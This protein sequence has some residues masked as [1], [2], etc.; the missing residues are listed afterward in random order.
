MSITPGGNVLGL[1]AAEGVL[2]QPGRGLMRGVLCGL[3]RVWLSRWK[4]EVELPE[5]VCYLLHAVTEDTDGWVPTT[6]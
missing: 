2:V 4:A 6:M 1:R 3:G 5:Q